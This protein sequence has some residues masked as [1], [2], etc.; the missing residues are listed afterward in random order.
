M[1]SLTTGRDEVIARAIL[2]PARQ[3]QH[4]TGDG[5]AIEFRFADNSEQPSTS[6]P[7]EKRRACSPA[8]TGI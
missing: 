1:K 8:E 5:T 6:W 4:N 2:R 3:G 7:A